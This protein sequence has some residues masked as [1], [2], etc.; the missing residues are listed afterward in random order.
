MEYKMFTKSFYR[1][2]YTFIAVS[3]LAGCTAVPS[4]STITP[5]QITT[6]AQSPTETPIPLLPGTTLAGKV[7][8]QMPVGLFAQAIAYGADAV[9]VPNSGDGTLSRIDP[10]TNQVVTTIKV[11]DPAR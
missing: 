2:L 8:A 10:Q 4:K 1:I 5:Q 9:W 3:V 6:A 11:G 7:S